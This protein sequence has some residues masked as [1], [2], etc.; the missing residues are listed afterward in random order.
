MATLASSQNQDRWPANM[1]LA[2]GLYRVGVWHEGRWVA[3][4]Q[5]LHV[6]L[7]GV[8]TFW[9]TDLDEAA[10]RLAAPGLPRYVWTWTPPGGKERTLPLLQA[11]GGEPARWCPLGYSTPLGYGSLGRVRHVVYASDAPQAVLG[12]S[13]MRPVLLVITKAGCAMCATLGPKLEALAR[14]AGSSL[15]VVD[16]PSTA[17]ST[18]ASVGAAAPEG[19]PTVLLY[20]MGRQ[21]GDVET[22]RI[23]AWLETPDSDLLAKVVRWVADRTGETSRVAVR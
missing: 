12:E 6:V 10:H 9:R 21:V 19:Y 8:Y 23:T 20:R 22:D 7:E 1:E 15:S 4:P 11:K 16:I 3:L 2:E 5:A 17:V 14:A 18:L 13:M